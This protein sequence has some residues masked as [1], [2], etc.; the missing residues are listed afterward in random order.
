MHIVIDIDTIFTFLNTYP[1]FK[2]FY[3]L[4]MAI[5]L[6]F[7]D[8]LASKFYDGYVGKTLENNEFAQ[9]M[10]AGLMAIVMLIFNI[11]F[12]FITCKPLFG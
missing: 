6:I 7:C 1:I 2:P 10:M 5:V 4:L 12:L 9:C 11:M 3:V 8:I